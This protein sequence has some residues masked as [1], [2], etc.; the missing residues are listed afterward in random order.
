MKAQAQVMRKTWRCCTCFT[1]VGKQRKDGCGSIV[2]AQRVD[3]GHVY[4]RNYQ[5][6]PFQAYIGCHK[7]GFPITFTERQAII[8]LQERSLPCDAC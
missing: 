8:L 6:I 7:Q 3:L 5:G 4:T 1:D 2:A